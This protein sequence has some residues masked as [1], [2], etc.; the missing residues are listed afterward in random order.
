MTETVTCAADLLTH[1][2]FQALCRCWERDYRAPLCLPDWLRE[3]GLE[4]QALVAEWAVTFPDRQHW[5]QCSRGCGPTPLHWSTQGWRWICSLG[6]TMGNY[7]DNINSTDN[8][9][10]RR[11]NDGCDAFAD[12]IAG[13]LDHYEPETQ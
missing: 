4:K 6:S 1:P 3:Q 13:L 2:E 5:H 8:Q 11:L 12:A 10:A 7:A 9:K